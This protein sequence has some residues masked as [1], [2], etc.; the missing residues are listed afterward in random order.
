MYFSFYIKD[1][2]IVVAVDDR[3]LTFKY[4][5]FIDNVSPID[6]TNIDDDY[7]KSLKIV[8][9]GFKTFAKKNMLRFILQAI[10]IGAAYPALSL[11]LNH[12][13]LTP[14]HRVLA[15]A[16][17]ILCVPLFLVG[18]WWFNKSTIKNY[19]NRFKNKVVTRI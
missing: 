5:I 17:A 2:Y 18:E 9:A 10:L 14:N 19:K 8:C 4:N 11:Y 7:K 12:E 1:K 6:K 3:E 16:V 15:F 13:V